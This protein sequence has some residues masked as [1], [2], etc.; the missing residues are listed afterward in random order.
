[1]TSGKTPGPEDLE[2]SGLPAPSMATQTVIWV[3]DGPVCV[4]IIDQPPPP[5]RRAVCG[6]AACDRASNSEPAV[7]FF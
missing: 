6:C 3:Q 4:T 7:R 2:A 5:V 1:M